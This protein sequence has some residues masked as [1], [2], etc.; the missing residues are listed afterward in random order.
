MSLCQILWGFMYTIS[1]VLAWS[2]FY[3]TELIYSKMSLMKEYYKL[4]ATGMYGVMG[5]VVYGQL[6]SCIVALI[7]MI[8]EAMK[9]SRILRRARV[10][11]GP[12]ISHVIC[13]ILMASIFPMASICIG[14]FV[15][16]DAAA[17]WTCIGVAGIIFCVLMF[18][19]DPEYY[20]SSY[21]LFSLAGGVLVNLNDLRHQAIVYLFIM[22]FTYFS[23]DFNFLGHI[24]SLIDEQ[25]FN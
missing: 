19:V 13:G 18:Y 23:D 16:D 2:S 15:E 17:L 4:F 8:D 24:K 5:F 21:A 10:I 22:L 14:V 3:C 6:F 25:S 7:E 12:I 9:E 20:V 11:L 1:F